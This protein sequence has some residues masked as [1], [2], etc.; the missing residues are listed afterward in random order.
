M[1]VRGQEIRRILAGAKESMNRLLIEIVD[2][3]RA[4]ALLYQVTKQDM[5]NSIM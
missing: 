5:A 3:M 1:G 2:Y 4:V